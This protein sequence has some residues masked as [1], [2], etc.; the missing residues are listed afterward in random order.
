MRIQKYFVLFFS[1][2]KKFLLVFNKFSFF[3]LIFFLFVY[4]Y[5]GNY[6]ESGMEVFKDMLAK[7]G[8]CIVYFY[9][10]YSNVG[11]QSF[12][13]LLKKFR[14]YLFKVRVVVCFCEGMIVRG[15]FMVMRRLGLVGEFLFLGR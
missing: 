6:G 14:S 10:I 12:D 15:L 4:F 5:I 13:K 1:Y 2:D 9:K 3:I 7:E 8:I 11:E